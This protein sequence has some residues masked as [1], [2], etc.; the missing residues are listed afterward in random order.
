MVG[1]EGSQWG[2]RGF[3]PLLPVISPIP[4][5]LSLLASAFLSCK[6]ERE[7]SVWAVRKCLGFEA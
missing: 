6:M 4:L 1:D 3:S 2:I 7:T 5:A